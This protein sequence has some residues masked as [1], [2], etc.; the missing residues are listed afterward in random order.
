ML[1]ICKKSWM[2]SQK[3]LDE[4]I[5]DATSKTWGIGAVAPRPSFIAITRRFYGLW[6]WAKISYGLWIWGI[7]FMVY[8]F[9]DPPKTPLIKLSP[10]FSG[11]VT[12]K[13][14]VVN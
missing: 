9:P 11:N 4:S 10:A 5:L 14:W 7:I 2:K 6:I 13:Y 3:L 12:Y 1:D 8:G